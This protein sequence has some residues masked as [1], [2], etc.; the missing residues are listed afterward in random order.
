MPPKGAKGFRPRRGIAKPSET[1]VLS[2]ACEVMGLLPFATLKLS[3]PSEHAAFELTS[4]PAAESAEKTKDALAS[5][6][7]IMPWEQT[8]E[9]SARVLEETKKLP[10]DEHEAL[11]KTFQKMTEE[12]PDEPPAPELQRGPEWYKARRFKL[13]A[14]QVASVVQKSP[15]MSRKKLL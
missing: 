14:S 8:E 7:G 9:E 12:A 10:G 15:F 6:G 4:L 2:S 1:D 5:E 11:A 3:T 13:S